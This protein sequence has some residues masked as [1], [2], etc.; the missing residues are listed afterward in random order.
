MKSVRVDRLSIEISGILQTYGQEAAGVVEKAV[1]TTA[2]DT[3]KRLRE[4]SPKRTGAYAKSWTSRTDRAKNGAAATVYAK[5]P[6]YRL[7]HLL[8]KGHIK[9]T[10]GRVE[11]HP[12]IAPAADEAER[13]LTAEITDGL[14]ALT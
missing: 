3:V 7:T 4:T 8:E 14:E 6:H 10:G 13:E 9:A 2:K 1:K 5:A 12:H 11:G